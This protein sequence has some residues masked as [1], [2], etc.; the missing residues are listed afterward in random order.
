MTEDT[1]F[2]VRFWGVRGSIACPG[3]E[4]VR[5]GGN[6]ACLEVRVGGHR[7][8]IDGG[9]GLRPLGNEIAKESPG[10]LDVFF[11]HAHFDHVCGVPF[12]KPAYMTSTRLRFWAGNL[13]PE[14][15][16]E[17]TL[18]HLMIAP[19]FPVPIHVFTACNFRDF[20]VGQPMEVRPGV[21]LNTCRLN[22]PNG[23]CGYR[24][25][26]GGRSLCIITD[27]EHVAGELDRTIV[28][29]V[30]DADIMVYDAMFT[31]E[32]YRQH[33]G[34]GHSTWEQ[35]LRVA[36]AANVRQVALFHHSPDHDDR[37]MERIEAAAAAARPG[38]VAARE[39]MILR[40]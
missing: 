34:W 27:T 4:T 21:S 26:Y 10:E 32:E 36:D 5:Y 33:V 14:T 28:E 37:A 23:A 15:T 12:F 18:C 39:G 16:L 30:R 13:L 11:T 7:L 25:D 8:I 31:E 29:F 6:T 20:A 9:T 38:T 19:L 3:P 35:A 17:T 22:H 2:H 24:I 1:D 40:P